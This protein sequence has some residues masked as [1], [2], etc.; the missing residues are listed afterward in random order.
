MKKQESFVEALSNILRKQNVLTPDSANAVKKAFKDGSKASFDT[1]LLGEGLV[2]RSALLNALSEYYH[3]PAFDVVGYFFDH[4]MLRKFPKDFLV[5][6]LIIP[7]EQD[8]NMLTVVA[9]DPNDPELLPKIGKI[10]SYDIQFLVGLDQDIIDAIEEFYDE[11]LTQ[12]TKEDQDV[13]DEHLA[14][15]ELDDMIKRGED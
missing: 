6:N 15:E 10:V 2:S 5:R 14:D 11:S 8:Q 1:F 13:H 7:L 3:V 4:D 9:G 12:D